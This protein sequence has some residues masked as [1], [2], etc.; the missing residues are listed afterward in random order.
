MEPWDGPASIAFTD[1]QLI[2]AVLDRNG[3][4]PCAL[5]RDQATTS[6]IMASEVGVL[7]VAARD[8]RAEGPPA[9]RPHVPGRHRA[10]PHRR[11]RGDQ[12][13]RSPRS[14]P[15][16][17]WLDENLVAPRRPARRPRCPTPRPGHAARSASRPSA[18]PSRTC[19]CCSRPMA[20][21]RRGAG[22]LDG[23]RHA[24][25]RALG[26]AAAALQLLQAALRPGHQS[27]AR[28]HPRGAGHVRRDAAS[29]PSA[30][31]S[32]RS[33]QHCRQLR[34]RAP[35]PDQRGAR[36]ASAHSRPDR[37]SRSARCRSCSTSTR[38]E[39]GPRQGAGR[40]LRRR[41]TQA[42]AEGRQRPRSCPTAASTPRTRADP[43][44]AGRRR[45]APPPDPRRARAPAS[46]S[47]SRPASRARCITSAC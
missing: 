13:A 35:D 38:G 14:S 20:A 28:L 8:R 2:G 11:R 6:S 43:R 30:T 47:S 7:D 21:Q 1:G 18:T 27:A 34:A 46:A 24:A 9:A 40:A 25:G 39:Q 37:A 44:A 4:R 31:C 32:T 33:P 3:L 26:P 41:P 29:A 42:I 16:G 15:T 19:A 23:H 12:A 5:L 10:G 45:P 36:Q 17:E 22:R